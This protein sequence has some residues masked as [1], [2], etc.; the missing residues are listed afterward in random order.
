MNRILLAG[1][2]SCV[3][4]FATPT[5]S[6]IGSSG[7]PGDGNLFVSIGLSGGWGFQF[8][9]DTTFWLAAATSDFCPTGVKTPPCDAN[10]WFFFNNE[11]IVTFGPYTDLFGMN[12]VV[13]PPSSTVTQ[14]FVDGVS[15]V[16]SLSLSRA[17][18]NVGD[19]QS[20]Q[21]IFVYD[22]Y[23]GDPN[24]G[25]NLI[26]GDQLLYANATVF[27]GAVMAAPEPSTAWL[28]G[29]GLTAAAMLKFTHGH[30]TRHAG[31]LARPP[32]TA[33]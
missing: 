33:L 16:G 12:F 21:I 28:I 9:N 18:I 15:G 22:T 19:A 27:A 13:I 3:A 17:G 26:I 20:G 32:G 1:M 5:A 30:R 7:N 29:F 6:L 31:R 24:N 8:I 4:A 25:G 11:K 14:Q 2:M 23:D 10:T